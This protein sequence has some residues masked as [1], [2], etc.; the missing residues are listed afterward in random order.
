[1]K[2]IRLILF[3]ALILMFFSV[4]ALS[5]DA[6]TDNVPVAEMAASE[7]RFESVPEG[8]RVTHDY[9]IHN[10]GTAPLKVIQVKTG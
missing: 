7:Y 6:K 2:I 8:T 1:M 10:R 3:F 4:P 5:L 9:I